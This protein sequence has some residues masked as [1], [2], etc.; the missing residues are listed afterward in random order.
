MTEC[1]ENWVRTVTVC[2]SDWCDSVIV[3]YETETA[4]VEIPPKLKTESFNGYG[5]NS[6]Q[7]LIIEGVMTYVCFNRTN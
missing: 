1:E 6:V 5:R 2:S 7:Y 3:H 4:F